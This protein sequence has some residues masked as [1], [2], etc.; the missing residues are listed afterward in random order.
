MILVYIDDFAVMCAI[1][2]V[3]G[4]GKWATGELKGIPRES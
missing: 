3:D 1:D 2:A 4:V